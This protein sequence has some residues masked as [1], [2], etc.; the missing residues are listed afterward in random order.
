MPSGSVCCS[1]GYCLSGLFCCNHG[2]AENGGEYCEGGGWCPAGLECMTYQGAQLCCPDGDCTESVT[3]PH[4]RLFKQLLQRRQRRTHRRLL[5]QP[6]PP[7][8]VAPD[9]VLHTTIPQFTPSL[10]A[11]ETNGSNVIYFCGSY[12]G[13]VIVYWFLLEEGEYWWIR[14]HNVSSVHVHIL[15]RFCEMMLIP[16]SSGENLGSV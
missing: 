16:I 4:T 1:E 7:L 5:L 9:I 10:L 8:L 2:C 13:L 11:C 6:R 14:G 12:H 15:R 3:V